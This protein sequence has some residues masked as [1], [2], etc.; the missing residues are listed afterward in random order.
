MGIVSARNIINA[1][2]DDIEEI[3]AAQIYFEQGYFK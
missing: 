3:G 1:K 2:R